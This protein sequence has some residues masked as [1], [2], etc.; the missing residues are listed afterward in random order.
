[1]SAACGP[2][3]FDQPYG[4]SRGFHFAETGANARRLIFPNLKLKLDEALVGTA[5]GNG[6]CQISFGL[7]Y[8]RGTGLSAMPLMS[9]NVRQLV[10]SM[11]DWQPTKRF[12]SCQSGLHAK[13]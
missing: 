10:V 9:G 1:M 12:S 11:D 2:E 13:E 6:D 8:R 3:W 7:C 5:T 4:V